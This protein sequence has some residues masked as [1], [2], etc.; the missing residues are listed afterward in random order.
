MTIKQ[1][2]IAFHELMR[3]YADYGA[4][5]TEP[6]NFFYSLLEKSV[7]GEELPEEI[8]ADEWQLYST[9][10]TNNEIADELTEKYRQLHYDIQEAPHKEI[11]EACNYY[12]F[13]Y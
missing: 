2:I 6:R 1:K 11:V 13:E 4:C 12:G 8:E 9:A 5:D 7:R 10:D 3:E